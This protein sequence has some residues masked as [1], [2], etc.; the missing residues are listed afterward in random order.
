MP[1]GF[2][3]MAALPDVLGEVSVGVQLSKGQRWDI[4]LQYDAE[5]GARYLSQSG[6]G[7]L[8]MTF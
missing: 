7:R 4:Q 5:A 6:G 8:V 1:Q 3:T 2:R